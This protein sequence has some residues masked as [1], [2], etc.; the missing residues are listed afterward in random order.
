MF[1]RTVA[2]KRYTH[3]KVDIFSKI[4]KYLINQKIGKFTFPIASIELA[5]LESLHNPSKIQQSLITEYIKRII[6]KHKKTMNLD[7]F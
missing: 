2:Y 6:R 1:D 3:Q 5:I 4:K 7:F